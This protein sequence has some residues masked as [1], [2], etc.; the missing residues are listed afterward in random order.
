[1]TAKTYR[2]R[3]T[4]KCLVCNA[5]ATGYVL[6]ELIDGSYVQTPVCDTHK[7]TPEA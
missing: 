7:Y 6:L 2:E 5:K 3:I 1:M 4:D